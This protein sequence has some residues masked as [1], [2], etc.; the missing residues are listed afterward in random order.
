M[1]QGL[2]HA[3]LVIIVAI[4]AVIHLVLVGIMIKKIIIN[5]IEY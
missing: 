3:L 4:L 1:M 2:L 5:M